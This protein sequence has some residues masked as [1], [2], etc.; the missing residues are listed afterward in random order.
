VNIY[1]YLCVAYGRFALVDFGLA[2]RLSESDSSQQQSANGAAV[3]QL[4]SPQ[5][6]A[7]AVNKPVRDK[8]YLF[9]FLKGSAISPFV[10]SITSVH[11]LLQF[12]I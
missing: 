10:H 9:W 5:L 1:F 12:Y 7:S 11:V 6:S 3:H 2:Q 4:K 8:Y